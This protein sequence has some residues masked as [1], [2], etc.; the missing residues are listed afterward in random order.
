[1]IV[2]S[3]PDWQG[4]L[5]AMQQTA[6]RGAHNA[7]NVM[8][9][10]AVGRELGIS[11]EDMVRAIKSYRP[12]AHRCEVVGERDGVVFVND[13]KATNLDAMIKAIGATPAVLPDE[14]NILLIAGGTGKG[15]EFHEAGPLLAKRVKAA[16]LI[17]ESRSAMREAWN[18]FTT[19]HL[20]DDLE[21]AV[22][23]A[24]E[25]G[26]SGDVVL[27]SPACASFDQF[28]GYTQRGDVFKAIVAGLSATTYSAS[29][30]SNPTRDS[31]ASK[32]S[33]REH[34]P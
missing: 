1:L 29:L 22:R 3:L 7:E 18:L 32:S 27:L 6:L 13:S 11:L 8:A 28:T 34:Q 33:S 9:A 19:C 15:Q 20:V 31:G 16:F 4:P 26:E 24:V 23:F 30:W 2:G 10:L 14:P 25:L 12:A 21:E 17:G 5:L